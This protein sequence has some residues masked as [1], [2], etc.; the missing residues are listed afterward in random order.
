MGW[1]VLIV[2]DSKILRGM[3]RRI[4][5]LTGLDIGQVHE[6]GGG[7]E[8]LEVLAKNPVDVVLADVNMPGMNGAELVQRIRQSPISSRT[9]V[10]V[11][12]SDRNQ[13]TMDT[14]KSLGIDAYITKPFRAETLRDVLNGVFSQ[15][16]S[17][18]V[19]HAR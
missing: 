8:A 5:G 14:M 7:H 12:S 13:V 11:I 3:V 16:R 2:D 19:S 1:N 17:P 6:A 10:V 15:G 4:L 9:H 18:G